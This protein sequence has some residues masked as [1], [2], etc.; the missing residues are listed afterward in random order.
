MNSKDA[1]EIENYIVECPQGKTWSARAAAYSPSAHTVLLSG[2]SFS[3]DDPVKV[4]VKHVRSLAGEPI[5]SGNNTATALAL[6]T[7]K[8]VFGLGAPSLF[9]F[10]I[11]VAWFA[12]RDL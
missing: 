12:R 1:E 4:T 3:P 2:F 5:S 10:F 11:A 8:Y 7:W 6:T 9:A